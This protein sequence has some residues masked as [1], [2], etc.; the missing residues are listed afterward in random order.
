MSTLA[1]TNHIGTL[2]DDVRDLLAEEITRAGDVC[3]T[4][5]FQTEGVLLAKMA[6]EV[7]P[8]IPILFIDTGYH[9]AETYAYRDR[10]VREW[11]LNLI[12]IEPQDSVEEQEKKHGLL[13][14]SSPD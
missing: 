2:L 6:I 9:F 8:D 5:S 4:C 3:I 13:Y 11:G 1:I 7:D 12:N 10:L 14:Q